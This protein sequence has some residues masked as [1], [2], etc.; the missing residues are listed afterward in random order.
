VST[1]ALPSRQQ[2]KNV[3]TPELVACSLAPSSIA[4]TA[5]PLYP[6]AVVGVLLVPLYQLMRCSG[7]YLG[8]TLVAKD[9]FFSGKGAT[10]AILGIIILTS[11]L[12]GLDSIVSLLVG[13]S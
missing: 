3:T 4:L 6:W 7:A 13:G 11:L 10:M 12:S 5:V 9:R 2:W 1:L 8:R